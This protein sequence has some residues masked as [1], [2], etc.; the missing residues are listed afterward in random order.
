MFSLDRMEFFELQKSETVSLC[1]K[2]KEK[3]G[4]FHDSIWHP[5]IM[6]HKFLSKY[7]HKVR[8][9]KSEPEI[10]LGTVLHRLCVQFEERS[11]TLTAT[12]RDV[13]SLPIWVLTK[14]RMMAF[15]LIDII[16]SL[17]LSYV[18]NIQSTYSYFL[19]NGQA[20]FFENM[21]SFAQSEFQEK[22]WQW[23]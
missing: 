8:C 23:L 2:M 20:T 5:P 15:H 1:V 16:I 18:T 6:V 12:N 13:F 19:S 21:I 10:I 14:N 22:N 9:Q 3:F 17:N 7:L 11:Q 4:S